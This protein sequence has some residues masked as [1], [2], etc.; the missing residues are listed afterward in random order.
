[1]ATLTTLPD[2][3]RGDSLRY[4]L[5]VKEDGVALDIT[6][7]RIT[8]TLKKSTMQEDDDAA[9]QQDFIITDPTAGL[10]EIEVL[11]ADTTDLEPRQYYWDIQ[12]V[13]AAGIVA[14]YAGT[15]T[16]KPDVTREASIPS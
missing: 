2:F 10:A 15:V 12:L 4:T 5:A 9:L 3:Y 1:M 14:T 13:T 16:C 6:G 7:A 8:L 11:P